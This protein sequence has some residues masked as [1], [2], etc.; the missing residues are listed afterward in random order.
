MVSFELGTIAVAGD[1]TLQN[2]ASQFPQL[3][4]NLQISINKCNSNNN[5]V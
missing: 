1:I 5:K 3:N 2:A 4:N